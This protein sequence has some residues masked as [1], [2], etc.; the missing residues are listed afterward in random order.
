ML[1]TVFTPT[2][3][4]AHTLE[5]LFDSL[6]AQTSREFEWLVVDDGSTDQTESLIKEFSAKAAFSVRYIYQTNGGKHR[7]HNA[8]IKLAAG[9]LVIILDSDDCLLPHAVEGLQES[10]IEFPKTKK[11]ILREF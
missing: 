3:N 8:A 2:Y 1:I 6:M 10:G 9:E 4:R 7:A 11:I 5:R